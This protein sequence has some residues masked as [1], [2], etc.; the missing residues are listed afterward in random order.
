LVTLKHFGCT[1][2][3]KHNGSLQLKKKITC[4]RNGICLCPQVGGII[5][6][7]LKELF[8]AMQMAHINFFRISAVQCAG[9]GFTTP[10]YFQ[11]TFCMFSFALQISF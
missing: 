3:F 5:F 10:L 9:E 7:G 4:F 8:P 1:F 11:F 2:E 6:S